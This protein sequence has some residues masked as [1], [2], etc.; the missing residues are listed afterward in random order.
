M[1]EINPFED[2]MKRF[3]EI[4]EQAKKLP[5]DL[6]GVT[7]E[8]LEILKHEKRAILINFPL[9]TSKGIRII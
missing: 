1:T 4:F 8:Q 5:A 2:T 6:W 3:D 9:K 7:K